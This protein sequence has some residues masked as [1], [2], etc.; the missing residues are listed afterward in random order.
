MAL[1][2]WPLLGPFWAGGVHDWPLCQMQRSPEASQKPEGKCNGSL[3][4]DFL[5][6]NLRTLCVFYLSKCLYFV[7]RW[8]Y[9][10]VV[11]IMMWLGFM[12]QPLC[13]PYL[14]C[15]LQ[16]RYVLVWLN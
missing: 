11:I 4:V 3:T 12:T 16:V 15:V 9:N 10:T 8:E 7:Y 6:H 1:Y 14:F 5:L 13:S 2:F